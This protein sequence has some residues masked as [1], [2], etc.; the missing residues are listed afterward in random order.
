MPAGGASE[1][2]LVERLRERFAEDPRLGE[3]G[4][5]VTVVAGIVHVHGEVA[6]VTRR[7]AVAEIAR[8]LA[9][10]LEVRNEVQVTEVATPD[11]GM[12]VLS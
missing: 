2:Y 9:P 6:S 7:A 5:E 3:L 10:D 4:L 11:D 12:E 1:H 8:E